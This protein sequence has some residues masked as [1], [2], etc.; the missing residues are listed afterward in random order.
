MNGHARFGEKTGWRD[1][2]AA[3][4]RDALATFDLSQPRL[5]RL[6][7][8]CLGASLELLEKTAFPFASRGGLQYL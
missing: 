3:H 8:V 7:L 1:G 6:L 5:F 4:K 2:F